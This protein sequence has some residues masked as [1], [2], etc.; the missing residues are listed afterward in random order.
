M[1]S[2][3]AQIFGDKEVDLGAIVTAHRNAKSKKSAPCHRTLTLTCWTG[4][5]YQVVSSPSPKG[6]SELSITR[7]PVANSTFKSW[8]NSLRD[9]GTIRRRF[10]FRYEDCDRKGQLTN[11]HHEV[12]AFLQRVHEVCESNEK[13]L[14][15]LRGHRTDIK[16]DLSAADK[17]KAGSVPV[18]TPATQHVKQTEFQGLAAAARSVN[19]IQRAYRTL[20]NVME[21]RRQQKAT[22]KLARDQV[23]SDR[24]KAATLIQKLFLG[25]LTRQNLLRR[26]RRERIAECATAIRS[27]DVSWAE[28]MISNK[29]VTVNA[30]DQNGWTLL[31]HAAANN[32]EEVIIKL[33]ELGADMQAR[34]SLGNTALHIACSRK[35]VSAARRLVLLGADVEVCNDKGNSPFVRPRFFLSS[36]FNELMAVQSK[37][38]KRSLM[39]FHKKSSALPISYDTEIR[40]SACRDTDSVENIVSAQFQ[41]RAIAQSKAWPISIDFSTLETNPNSPSNVLPH[42]SAEMRPLRAFHGNKSGALTDRPLDGVDYTSSFDCGMFQQ[43]QRSLQPNGWAEHKSQ[44]PVDL[45]ACQVP[46]GSKVSSSRSIFPGSPEKTAAVTPIRSVQTAGSNGYDWLRVGTAA[47]A[48]VQRG[49]T[50]Q[51]PD[52]KECQHF[53]F[54]VKAMAHRSQRQRE[55]MI[56][57]EDITRPKQSI[58]ASEPSWPSISRSD[59]LTGRGMFARK[60]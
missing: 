8:A 47:N 21:I 7:S 31:H 15:Q 16:L 33:V 2:S 30:I 28:Q 44:V 43:I 1:H 10:L 54:H 50:E 49:I 17:R 59:S 26:R 60:I 11:T 53:T 42:L 4:I 20:K 36:I 3:S 57:F 27:G 39:T 12:S 23:Q 56:Q 41:T 37:S 13:H 58:F 32:R 19:T 38:I 35:K 48:A 18:V 34:D 46:S 52:M 6:T 29:G 25:C 5:E 9:A 22:A 45:K 14:S 40:A 51:R 55:R 24:D